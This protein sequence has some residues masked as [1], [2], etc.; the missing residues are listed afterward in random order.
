MSQIPWNYAALLEYVWDITFVH[1][2][3][4]EKGIYISFVQFDW[5]ECESKPFI[6]A[7]PFELI[8]L[9]GNFIL[10]FETNE[11]LRKRLQTPRF[12]KRFA[13]LFVP[14]V[15]PESIKTPIG[16]IVL[17]VDFEKGNNETLEVI[18]FKQPTKTL[19]DNLNL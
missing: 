14:G 5:F 17:E 3:K 15:A 4:N 10:R 6:G 1:F 8:F 16:K 18:L 12:L 9:E 19:R 7:S 13:P 2:G 11:P